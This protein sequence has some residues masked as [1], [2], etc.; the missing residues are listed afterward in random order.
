M[1]ITT[2]LIQAVAS[3]NKAENLSKFHHPLVKDLPNAFTYAKFL[4]WP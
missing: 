2:T 3:C 1:S 4:N